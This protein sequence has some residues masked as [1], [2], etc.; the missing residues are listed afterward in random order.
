MDWR[1]VLI[2][3]NTYEGVHSGQI[4]FPGGK[5]EKTDKGVIDTAY[6]EAFEEL[7][8]VRENTE[9]VC[10]LTPIYIPPSNFTIYP[11]LTYA[12]EELRFSLDPREVV[13][14][15]EIEI[16]MFNP[17]FSEFRK[18]ETIRG[19]WVNAPGFVIGDYFVWGATA[20]ILSELYQLVAEAKLSISLSNMYISSSKPSI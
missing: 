19:E 15:K 3:R 1:V 13:E 14:Y 5:C 17:E 18:L 20:M 9:T 10:Q 4:A 12:K 6:R 16:R 2:K 8:I 11:V 7:G